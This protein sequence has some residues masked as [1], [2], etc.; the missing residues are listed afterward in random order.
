[1]LFLHAYFTHI[2]MLSGA[3]SLPNI[4]LTGPPEMAEDHQILG[5]GGPL[6]QCSKKVI[7]N[8]GTWLT[9]TGYSFNLYRALG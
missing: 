4:V 3:L 2:R 5:T 7:S 9:Y 8:P 1:M 6:G